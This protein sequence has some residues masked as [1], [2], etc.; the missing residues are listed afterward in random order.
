MQVMM[1]L[2]VMQ[3]VIAVVTNLCGRHEHLERKMIQAIK[4]EATNDHQVKK[5]FDKDV[6]NYWSKR[7]ILR[8][9][10]EQ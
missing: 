1:T 10:L 3:A 9:I 6:I 5:K 7:Q 8:E 4:L 2:S